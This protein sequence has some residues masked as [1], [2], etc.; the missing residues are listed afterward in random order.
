MFLYSFLE[1]VLTHPWI[2]T[3]LFFAII[4]FLFFNTWNLPMLATFKRG[5]FY[6]SWNPREKYYTGSPSPFT[7]ASNLE[8]FLNK[9]RFCENHLRWWPSGPRC[10]IDTLIKIS[11]FLLLFVAQI[12]ILSPHTFCPDSHAIFQIPLQIFKSFQ[13]FLGT[14]FFIKR[15]NYVSHQC[16]AR[17][18]VSGS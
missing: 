3:L 4:I 15:F 13:T 8:T 1:P 14:I 10:E 16:I 11:F 18:T 2:T 7:V 17:I 12:L 5:F 9:T 6:P